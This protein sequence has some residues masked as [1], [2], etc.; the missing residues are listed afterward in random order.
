[1]NLFNI[2]TYSSIRDTW[3]EYT[4]KGGVIEYSFQFVSIYFVMI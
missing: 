2:A 4:D 3:R 1:L